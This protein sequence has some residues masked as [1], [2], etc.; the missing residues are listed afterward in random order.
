MAELINGALKELIKPEIYLTGCESDLL[1]QNHCSLPTPQSDLEPIWQEVN[2]YLS[3]LIFI[4][5]LSYY[6]AKKEGFDTNQFRGGVDSEK[7]VRGSYQTIRQS[8]ISN[9]KNQ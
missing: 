1:L 9:I 4:E 8:E 6:T 3:S 7:Y 2:L 5:W